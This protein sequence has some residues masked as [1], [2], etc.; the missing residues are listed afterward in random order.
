MLILAAAERVG[1]PGHCLIAIEK[2]R[3]TPDRYPRP[4]AERQRAPLLS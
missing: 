4:A 2:R 3:E 1:L